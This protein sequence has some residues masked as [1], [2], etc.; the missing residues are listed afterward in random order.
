MTDIPPWLKSM[1]HGVLG[2]T[3]A[4]A[5]LLQRFW[6]LSRSV[7][8][9]GADYLIQ[10]RLTGANFLDQRAP[11]LGVVQV[12]FIQDGATT[13]KIP[14]AYVVDADEKPY[15]EFF[16]LVCTGQED[17]QRM[18]LLS[19]P[20]IVAEFERKT[21]TRKDGTEKPA[22][23]LKGADLLALGNYE[24]LRQGLKLDEIENAL[25]RADLGDN[26]RFLYR[27]GYVKPEKDHIDHDF[28]LPLE[29]GWGDIG[30]A[31]FENKTKMTSTLYDLEELVEAAE[32]II[33][34]TD[35]EE[36]LRIY[37]DVFTQH[38]G[39]GYSSRTSLSVRCEGFDD[40]EFATTVRTHR[41][42]LDAIRALGVEAAYFDL[43]ATYR[44]EVARQLEPLIQSGV[45]VV[46][47]KTT[48]DPKTLRRGIIVVTAS[49][50]TPKDSKVSKS[51][52]GRQILHIN[53]AS[54]ATAYGRAE[55]GE[56]QKAITG[57]LW[58]LSQPFIAALDEIYLGA[59]LV[60][61]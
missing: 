15:G 27:S 17:D 22:Y 36:A 56:A 61:C 20:A 24:V 21:T 3:R 30:S 4:R 19:A 48:Y 31:F 7:D 32:K 49:S 57:R 9:D 54:I 59:D 18:F 16:V 11:R 8:I 52:K 50:E 14:T 33:A 41:K 53:V 28:N 29:N 37:D 25:T 51:E 34:T 26:R 60:A 2:E 45:T 5:F 47:V 38:I 46:K 23:M 10:R 39:G 42:R 12:K 13:I 35:P 6:V 44:S 55:T 40:D 43:V 1:E 58:Q